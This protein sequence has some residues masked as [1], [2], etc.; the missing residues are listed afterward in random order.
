MDALT[1]IGRVQSNAA[2]PDFDSALAATRATLETLGE[3][4]GGSNPSDL[5]SQ[6]PT[7]LQLYLEQGTEC[8]PKVFDAEE[9]VERVSRRQGVDTSTATTSAIAVMVTLG[10]AVTTGNLL[11]VIEQ[12]PKDL[13]AIS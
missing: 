9:F 13:E 11:D 10:E 1:F 2:L 5:A 4:L 3:R 7:E 8:G 6:L 12:F